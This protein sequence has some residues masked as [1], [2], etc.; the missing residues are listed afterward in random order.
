MTVKP[1]L[2]VPTL[3][4]NICCI[5]LLEAAK[6][7]LQSNITPTLTQQKRLVRHLHP[8]LGATGSNIVEPTMLCDHVGRFSQVFRVLTLLSIPVDYYSPARHHCNVSLC[9]DHQLMKQGL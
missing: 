8:T 1:R 6:R 7:H 2:N 9:R 4:Y 5:T 3:L